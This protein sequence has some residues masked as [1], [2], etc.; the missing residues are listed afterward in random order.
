M[1]E[2][3][4]ID[5]PW[6]EG[7]RG[8]EADWRGAS[9]AIAAVIGAAECAVPADDATGMNEA[10]P[11]GSKHRGLKYEIACTA[12]DAQDDRMTASQDRQ[13]YRRVRY[14]RAKHDR[15]SPGINMFCFCKALFATSA[16]SI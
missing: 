6:W 12:V 9:L 4:A 11:C 14:V 3:V 15:K 5:I 1:R 7:V 16:H 13:M 2:E 8:G 10:G